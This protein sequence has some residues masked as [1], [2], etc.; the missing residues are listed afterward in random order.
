MEYNSQRKKYL[1]SAKDSKPYKLSRTRIENYLS[2]Q[3]CFFLDRKCGTEQPPTFPYTLNNAVDILLKDEFDKYRKMG[4]PHPYL[5]KYGINAIPFAHTDLD[6]W[7]N[8]QIGIKYHHEATNF[9]ITGAIDDVWINSEGELIIVDYKALCSKKDVTLDYR[10]S[11]KRQL[12]I[13]QWL[14][15]KNGFKVSNIG[16]FIFC[17]ADSTKGQFLGNLEFNVTLVSYI[18][19]D[20]WIDKTLLNIKKCLMN[21]KLPKPSPYC[22]YC[23]YFIAL[24]KH[25]SKYE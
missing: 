10:N 9:I 8:T 17:N 23:S 20:S 25:I 7:R 19:D 1:F 3:R 6:N 2:C 11:Y 13:Y 15:R 5:I 18:A 14:L 24:K 22:N 4:K 12:E 16:Y 21:D